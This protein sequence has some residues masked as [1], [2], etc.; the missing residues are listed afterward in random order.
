[1]KNLILKYGLI[2]GVIVGLPLFVLT[3]FFGH[4]LPMAW[5]MVIGYTSMLIAF[6][7]ILVATKRHRD[8]NLG[9]V[10]RF[11]PAFAMGLGITLVASLIYVLT[12][13]AVMASSTQD[14]MAIY[15]KA[16]LEQEKANGASAEALAKM[17]A[18][19]Q[20]FAVMYAKPWYRMLITMT[21]ILPIGVLVSLISAV[22]I[23]RPG[24][25]PARSAG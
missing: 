8:Q 2:A 3:V 15:G 17:A 22:L 16:M 24:F 18:E 23:R 7:M 5:G 14:F 19:M 10:I 6:S 4:N 1:M 11:W 9:G 25:M 12:W 13:E 20:E 21:E